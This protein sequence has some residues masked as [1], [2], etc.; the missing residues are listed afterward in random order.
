MVGGALRQATSLSTG[1]VTAWE[2]GGQELAPAQLHAHLRKGARWF[3][4]PGRPARLARALL[5][6]RPGCWGSFTL[7]GGVP[8]PTPMPFNLR[9]GLQCHCHQRQGIWYG[10]RWAGVPP[11]EGIG[12][13][14]RRA[15]YR[16]GAQLCWWASSSSATARTPAL[17]LQLVPLR[18][19]RATT[20]PWSTSQRVPLPS[21]LW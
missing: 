8:A 9:A 20:A 10:G 18:A 21:Y 7:A 12:T 13:P 3:D 19:D 1:S 6:R 17:H 16:L 4:S 2:E 11:G 14:E 5:A 15:G